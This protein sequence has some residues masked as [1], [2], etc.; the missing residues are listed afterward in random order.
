MDKER[1]KIDTS[2]IKIRVDSDPY[3]IFVGRQ[4][5]A[6]IDVFDMRVKRDYFLIIS[7]VSLSLV[8]NEIQVQSGGSLIG[9]NL[10]INKESNE[11]YSKYEVEVA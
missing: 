2:S 6:A 10:W 9:V 1:L 8:L 7:P 5:V 4:Y 3:A 11:K